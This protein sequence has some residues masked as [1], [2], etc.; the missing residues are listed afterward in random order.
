MGSG[1]LGSRLKKLMNTRLP[2][3]CTTGHRG[4]R[5]RDTRAHHHTALE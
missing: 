4:H 2:A 5:T 1:Q 3:L